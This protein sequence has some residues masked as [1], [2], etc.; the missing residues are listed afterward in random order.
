MKRH[1]SSRWLLAIALVAAWLGAVRAAG[2]SPAV[3]ATAA[4]T[5]LKSLTPEQRQQASFPVEGDEWTHWHF[6]PDRHVSAEGADHQVD[7]RASASAGPQAA[8]VRPQ[9]ARL[10]DRDVDHGSRERPR[11]ARSGAS[12]RRCSPRQRDGARSRAL[13]LFGLRNALGQGTWGWRVEGHHVSL[14]FMVV[15][16]T[17]VA[18]SPSF[19]GS[20]PAEVREGPKKGL[21]ILAAEEDSA[22]SLVHGAC[23]GATEKQALIN[24]GR[25]E[26]H[27]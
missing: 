24:V 6:I 23:T 17:L 19:F 25:A 3:M 27:S 15:N 11:R 22:R 2:R 12:N 7:D 14:H 21:R 26:R 18:S 10:F 13:F 16:G 4:D 8:R 20:N 5:F 1:L 9:P